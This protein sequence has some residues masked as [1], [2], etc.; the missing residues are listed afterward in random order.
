MSLF[1]TLKRVCD[2]LG[3]EYRSYSG[4]GMYGRRCFAIQS[5]D[6]ENM[7]LLVDIAY[8]FG[9]QSED[10][11]GLHDIRTDSMGLGSVMYW[12]NVEWQDTDD[13]ED[14]SD[15]EFAVFDIE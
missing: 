13:S 6:C 11:T 15:K 9:E 7:S 2:E 3:I 10:P 5:D 8:S 4:R 1:N 14:D 12:P